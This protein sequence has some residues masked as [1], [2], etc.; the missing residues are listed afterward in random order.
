VEDGGGLTLFCTCPNLRLTIDDLR[1]DGSYYVQREFQYLRLRKKE[2]R[3]GLPRFSEL[4][5]KA[6]G[7][8]G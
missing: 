5:L 6:L 8:D 2:A 7:V 1:D 4:T 3:E